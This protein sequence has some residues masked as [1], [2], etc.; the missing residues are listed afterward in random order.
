MVYV[1]VW[2][3]FVDYF[4]VRTHKPY[5][6]VFRCQNGSAKTIPIIVVGLQPVSVFDHYRT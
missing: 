5:S 1:S 2:T 4:P 6:I 3:M